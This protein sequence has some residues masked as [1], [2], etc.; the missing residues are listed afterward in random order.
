MVARQWAETTEEEKEIWKLRAEQLKE[1]QQSVQEV[2]ML[3][4]PTASD[5]GDKKRPAKKAK[6]TASV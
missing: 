5:D 2:G 3:Q 1:E 6:T 4:L